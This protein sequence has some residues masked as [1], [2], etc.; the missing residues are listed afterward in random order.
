MS[1]HREYFP[2]EVKE[3]F[4]EVLPSGFIDFVSNH[5]SG[6]FEFQNMRPF[7]P[8][9][10]ELILGSNFIRVRNVIAYE[11]KCVPKC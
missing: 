7:S 2:G 11:C 4:S 8:G 9:F 3:Y 5:T 1:A 6:K 10:I